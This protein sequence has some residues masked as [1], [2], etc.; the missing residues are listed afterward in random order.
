MRLED[1]PAVNAARDRLLTSGRKLVLVEPTASMSDLK[2]DFPDMLSVVR[3]IFEVHPIYERDYLYDSG[4]AWRLR[5]IAARL[6]AVIT[7]GATIIQGGR[8]HFKNAP[9]VVCPRCGQTLLAGSTTLTFCHAPPAQQEQ[10]VSGWV[11]QCGEA[12]VPGAI[13]RE[14][15][16]AAFRYREGQDEFEI[17]LS[18]D[19]KHRLLHNW[20]HHGPQGPIDGEEDPELP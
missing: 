1:R 13:A 15:H 3:E 6:P 10:V 8:V 18:N 14:A 5:T 17:Q 7:A 19:E 12:Y 2:R 4:E 9:Q 11:C 16:A 20:I